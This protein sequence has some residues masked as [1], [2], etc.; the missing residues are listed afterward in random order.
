MNNLLPLIN[1]L[2]TIKPNIELGTRE[3]Y[4][5]DIISEPPINFTKD[6]PVSTLDRK[7]FVWKNPPESLV[8][9]LRDSGCSGPSGNWIYYPGDYQGWHT[10]SDVPGQR[11]Y[12]AWASESYQSGMRFIVD[13]QEIYSPD[14]KGWNI[15]LFTP[16]VWHMV[17]SN[18][19]RAS[20]G[21]IIKSSNIPDVIQPIYV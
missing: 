10:N 4:K 8:S 17:Y 3:V 14:K 18:C 11:L 6:V 13:N 12:V 9:Y 2:K 20:V 5:T 7:L 21:F 16:P 1:L 15:R 19:I